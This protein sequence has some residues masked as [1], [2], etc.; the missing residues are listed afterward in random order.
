MLLRSNSLARTLLTPIKEVQIRVELVKLSFHGNEYQVPWN[1]GAVP[2]LPFL[3][4]VEMPGVKVEST[5]KKT[6][7]ENGTISETLGILK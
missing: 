2:N 5:A 3:K 1:S 6:T 4:L 7:V